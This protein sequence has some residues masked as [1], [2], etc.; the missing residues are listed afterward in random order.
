MFL[1]NRNSADLGIAKD[2]I[3]YSKMSLSRLW[4]VVVRTSSLAGVQLV[5]LVN[6]VGQHRSMHA[7]NADERSMEQK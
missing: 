1:R 4:L 6:A 2:R 5:I 7:N 3:F